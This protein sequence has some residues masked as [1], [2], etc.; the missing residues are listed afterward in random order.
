MVL[1][2]SALVLGVAAT[3][4][5]AH[6]APA[7]DASPALEAQPQSGATSSV[8]RTSPESR[9]Q[10]GVNC[11]GRIVA[12]RAELGLPKLPE[13]G[14]KPGDP[15]FLAAVARTIDGCDVLVMRDNTSDF[16]PLPQ[17]AEGPGKVMPLGGQ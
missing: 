17:F 8:W 15:L 5:P 1:F 4:A 7:V 11:R 14:A 16:R 10:A 9:Q 12:A 2:L 13:D 6:L 3:A